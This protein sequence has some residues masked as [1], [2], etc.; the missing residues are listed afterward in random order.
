[1]KSL[2][3]WT[4]MKTNRMAA[5]GGGLPI[6]STQYG[7]WLQDRGHLYPSHKQPGTEYVN[8]YGNPDKVDPQNRFGLVVYEPS[9]AEHHYPKVGDAFHALRRTLPDDWQIIDMIS[10]DVLAEPRGWRKERVL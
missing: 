9:L 1:M 5:V 3:E 2:A 4:F 7:K 10:G 6:P 8:I